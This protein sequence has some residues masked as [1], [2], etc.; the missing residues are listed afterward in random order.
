[1][2]ARMTSAKQQGFIPVG[3][4]NYARKK[5][6]TIENGSEKQKPRSDEWT[7]CLISVRDNQDQAAFVLLF[8]HFAPRVKSYL[9]KSGGSGAQAEE[10]TQEALATVWQKAGMFNPAQSSA[11]TWIFTIARNKNIDAIRKQKRP[12]P[13]DI[14]WMG[15]EEDD[16]SVALETAQEESGLRRAVGKLP[17]AQRE[18][19]ERAFF[20]D[21]SHSEIAA[22]TGIALGTIK[23]RIRLG[24]ER[25]RHELTRST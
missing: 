7:L 18:L 14:S 4:M 2:I 12:E 1:M 15:A 17:D 8:N 9:M 13:E 23:S 11:S 16:A 19:I 25:I 21:M 24:L 10:A 5:G 20:G 3:V 6:E 22:E